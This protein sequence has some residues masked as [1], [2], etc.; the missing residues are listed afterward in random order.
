MRKHFF[1]PVAVK[2]IQKDQIISDN[3]C[4]INVMTLNKIV[5]CLEKVITEV[6]YFL[7]NSEILFKTFK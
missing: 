7:M 5:Y 3:Y 6:R 1:H 4:K 2:T